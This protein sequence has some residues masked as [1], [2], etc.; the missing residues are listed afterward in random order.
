[1]LHSCLFVSVGGL[2]NGAVKMEDIPDNLV[3]K[4][5]VEY[6]STSEGQRS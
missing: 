4:S 5:F 2:V 1:M 3:K 6:I